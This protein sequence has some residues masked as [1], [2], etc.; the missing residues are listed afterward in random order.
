MEVIFLV[1][2]L[3]PPN[4]RKKLMENLWIIKRILAKRESSQFLFEV[5]HNSPTIMH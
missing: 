2:T 4:F 3:T 5:V 1:Q